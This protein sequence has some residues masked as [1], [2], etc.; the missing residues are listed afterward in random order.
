MGSASARSSQRSAGAA[1][2][3]CRSAVAL[4]RQRGDR[5]DRCVLTRRTAHPQVRQSVT[6]IDGAG[7]SAD[8]GGSLRARHYSA[9]GARGRVQRVARRRAGAWLRDVRRRSRRGPSHEGAS[10]SAATAA[11]RVRGYLQIDPP[12]LRTPGDVS[13]ADAPRPRHARTVS[14]SSSSS[15]QSSSCASAGWK[16]CP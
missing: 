12:S 16:R 10:S 2:E 9:R 13:R 11:A 4:H 14:W 3:G 1:L 6:R 15:A 7:Y 8:G 5:R